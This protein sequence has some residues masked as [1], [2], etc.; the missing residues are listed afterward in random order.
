MPTSMHILVIRF[1][2]GNNSNTPVSASH[3]ILPFSLCC[4]LLQCCSVKNVPPG[5][6]SIGKMLVLHKL[7]KCTLQRSTT[8]ATEDSA[9]AETEEKVK[10]PNYCFLNRRVIL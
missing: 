4:P 10:C 8:S 6:D 7:L 5:I 3:M 1:K 2:N 9:A